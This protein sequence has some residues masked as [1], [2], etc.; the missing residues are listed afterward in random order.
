MKI[1]HCVTDDKFIDGAISLYDEDNRVENRW[2]HFVNEK[3][4]YLTYIKSKKVEVLNIDSFLDVL[5]GYDVVILHS[6]PSLPVEQINSIPDKIKI[7]WYAWGYD[8]YDGWNPLIPLSL[9][10]PLTQ[11]IHHQFTKAPTIAKAI[12]RKI[13]TWILPSEYESILSKIDYFSGVFPYEYDLIKKKYAKF[14]ALPVDFYYASVDFFIK[15]TCPFEISNKM[16]NVMLGNSANITNNHADVLKIIE[17]H[18]TIPEGGKV[19]IPLSYGGT[20]EYVNIVKGMAYNLLGDKALILDTY[21]PIERYWALASNCKIAIYA[22]VRQQASDNIFYQI[23]SGAKVYFTKKSAA[24]TY[25]KSLGLKVYSLED[26]ILTI[27]DPISHDEIIDN[28]KILTK[29]YSVSTHIRRVKKI[30]TIILS[31][32]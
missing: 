23:M 13:K 28:R 22:H 24:F 16:Q 19:I 15:D 8:L 31:S 18:I 12:K 14:R 7:V 10:L 2:V 1:L 26:D 3:K 17:N 29:F 27:N 21:M 30:N 5:E 20:L 25:L 32:L 4:H 6:L 11:K 9:Y